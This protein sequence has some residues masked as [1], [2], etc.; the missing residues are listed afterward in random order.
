MS[1]LLAAGL[2]MSLLAL[3]AEFFS[4]HATADGEAAA[5]MIVSGRFRVRFWLWVF[6]LCH[7]VPIFLLAA[8]A[9]TGAAILALIGI[10]LFE[11]MFVEAGQSLPLA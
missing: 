1:R 6:L 5:K 7:L 10:A 11:D 8:G 4:R 9:F 2:A 3:G